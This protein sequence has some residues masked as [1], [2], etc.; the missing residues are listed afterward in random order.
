MSNRYVL[1]IVGL[2]ATTVFA[3]CSNHKLKARTNEISKIYFASGGCFGSCPF[4]AIE[5]DSSLNYK[6]Y[7]GLYS[8]KQG[9]FTGRIS[10]ELWDS[11]NIKFEEIDFK[12]LDTSYQFSDDD[13]A[14]QTSIFYSNK[15]KVI[16]A[17]SAS[18]PQAVSHVLHWLM[19]SYRNVNLTPSKDTIGFYSRLLYPPVILPPPV[20]EF[21]VPK[22]ER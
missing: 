10:P 20:N 9:Y 2:F 8:E 13:L 3:A 16:N 14:T 12:H 21:K 4:L 1:C 5:V 15:R 11:I 17:Q 18:L 7:G 19:Y 6:Y 22:A